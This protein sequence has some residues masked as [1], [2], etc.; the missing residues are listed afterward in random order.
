MS[1]ITRSGLSVWSTVISRCSVRSASSLPRKKR[2]TPHRRMV[3][4]AAGYPWMRYLSSVDALE[5][6]LALIR[7]GRF[8]EAHEELEL[9]WRAAGPADRDFYQGLVHV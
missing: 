1:T 9:A 4:T 6:G 5:R 2:S 7:E 3:A 8:F